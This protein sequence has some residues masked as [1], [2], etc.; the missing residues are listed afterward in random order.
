VCTSPIRT[1]TSY[2]EQGKIYCRQQAGAAIQN[3]LLAIHEKGL[4]TC[5]VGSFVER[6]VKETLKIP[7]NIDVEAILP[8][9]YEFDKSQKRK[10]KIGLDNILY[11][12]KFKNSKMKEPKM[13]RV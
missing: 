5:W 3:F 8:I 13:V 2:G 7:E 4:A 1:I 9:G 10:S 12:N 6:L 11:F